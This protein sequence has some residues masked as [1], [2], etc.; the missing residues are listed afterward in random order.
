MTLSRWYTSVTFR[1]KYMCVTEIRLNLF[2]DLRSGEEE[3]LQHGHKKRVIVAM[4]GLLH[5][6]QI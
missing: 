3:L 5:H 1:G 6:E 4:S 2:S